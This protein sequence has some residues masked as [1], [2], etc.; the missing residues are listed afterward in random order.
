MTMPPPPVYD[1]TGMPP[2]P[3]QN[4]LAGPTSYEIDIRAPIRG[5]P[6][7]SKRL[8]QFRQILR[9]LRKHHARRGK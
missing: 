9:R 8:A 6:V 5:A 4:A 3:S 1:G 7:T 2:T